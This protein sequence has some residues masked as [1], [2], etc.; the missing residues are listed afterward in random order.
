MPQLAQCVVFEWGLGFIITVVAMAFAVVVLIVF[1]IWIFGLHKSFK[2]ASRLSFK[3]FQVSGPAALCFIV[4]AAILALGY[5]VYWTYGKIENSYAVT[6]D[7]ATGSSIK[8]EALRDKFQGDTQATITV[9]DSAKNFLVSGRFEGSCVADL[10]QSICRHYED[11]ISCESS[12]IH[13][14]VVVDARQKH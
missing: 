9:R 10:F 4:P 14:S 3:S 1:V 2:G 12:L 6:Y 8:L 7:T 5:A 13:G 11:R